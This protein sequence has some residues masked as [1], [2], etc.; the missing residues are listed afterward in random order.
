MKAY[1]HIHIAALLLALAALGGC[2]SSLSVDTPRVV[3]GT[4]IVAKSVVCQLRVTD[5]TGMQVTLAMNTDSAAA[6]I[7]TLSS[8][9]VIWLKARLK[10]LSAP[11][12]RSLPASFLQLNL[13][14]DSLPAWGDRL[15]L[16]SGQASYWF[17]N[18]ALS[19][20]SAQKEVKVDNTSN[21]LHMA[22]Y[23]TR[24]KRIM[25][26]ELEGAVNPAPTPNATPGALTISGYVMVQY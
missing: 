8:P 16:N 24:E 25:T 23:H 6:L 12:A 9:G 21:V 22:V 17:Y 4:P 19:P 14:L 1:Q 20:D 15:T 13:T 11:A 5:P 3:M 2:Q 18:S 10:N 7:D 26:L